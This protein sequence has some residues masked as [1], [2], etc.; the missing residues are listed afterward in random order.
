MDDPHSFLMTELKLYSFLPKNVTL[1]II[2]PLF[3]LK[4]V[5]VNGKRLL[6]PPGRKES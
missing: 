6:K 1:E 5:S 2:C 3:M 4:V